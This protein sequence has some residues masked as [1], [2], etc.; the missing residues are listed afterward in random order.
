MSLIN[1]KIYDIIAI[2]DDC[3]RVI[4]ETDEDYLYSKKVFEEVTEPEQGQ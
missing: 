3:Y 1:G 2:E 4:D